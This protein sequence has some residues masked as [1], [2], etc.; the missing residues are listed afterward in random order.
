MMFSNVDSY[1]A[2]HT[3]G[4]RLGES[5]SDITVE[6]LHRSSHDAICCGSYGQVAIPL[7]PFIILESDQSLESSL[8]LHRGGAELLQY[9]LFVSSYRCSFDVP[10][11]S[12]PFDTTLSRSRSLKSSQPKLTMVCHV[13][14]E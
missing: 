11:L 10:L 1:F 5:F 6:Y 3:L 7:F 12:Q 2:N 9:L 4:S 13:E 8:L 14:A